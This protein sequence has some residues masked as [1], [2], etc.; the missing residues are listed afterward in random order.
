VRVLKTNLRALQERTKLLRNQMVW[1]LEMV[2]TV[3]RDRETCSAA[4]IADG[5]QNTW[6]QI[7]HLAVG[8]GAAPIFGPQAAVDDRS[9]C[10]GLGIPRSALNPS[11]APTVAP[12]NAFILGLH[13]G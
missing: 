7:D 11:V 8:L 2:E 1:T 3:T 9:A 5:F 4:L 12:F 13:G 6:S 10:A